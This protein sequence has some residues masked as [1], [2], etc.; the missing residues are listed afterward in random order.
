MRIKSITARNYK[1]HREVTVQLD[2]SCT[3]IGGPNECGK[4]TLAEAAHR[5][6]FLKAKIT[7][8]TQ[9]GMVPFNPGGQPEVE[10][11]FEAQGKDY[12]LFKRFSGQTGMVRLSE[13]GG[14]SWQDE[15]AEEQL[16]K[17]LAV[18]LAGG[19]RG[20]G[21]RAAQQWAH[22]WVWQGQAGHDPAKHANDHRDSLMSRLQAGGGAAVMQSDRDAQVARGF[23]ELCESI[24]NRNGSPKANSDLAKAVEKGKEAAAGEAEAQELYQRLQQAISDYEQARTAIETADTSLRLLT[25]Q[26][27]EVDQKLEQVGKL[28]QAE[29]LQVAEWEM[30]SKKHKDLSDADERIQNLRKDLKARREALQPKEAEANRLNVVAEE[31]KRAAKAALSNYETAAEAARMARLERDLAIAHELLFEKTE[32]HNQLAVKAEEVR[33]ERETRTRLE[34]ELAKLPSLDAAGLKKLR[35]LETE[36]SN[37]ESALKAMAA[38]IEV[39]NAEVP[40]NAGGTALATGAD[41]VVTEDTELTI[42]KAARLRIKPGGGTSLGQ[43]RQN[44]REANAKL[45]DSLDKLGLASLESASEALANRELTQASIRESEVRLSTLGADSVAEEV[46]AAQLAMTT[47]QGEVDRRKEQLEQFAAPEALAEAK[48]L[49]RRLGGALQEKESNERGLKAIRDEALGASET[50]D[51]Q[52]VNGRQALEK[53]NREIENLAIELGVLTRTH[54]EDDARSQELNRLFGEKTTADER[55][56]TTRSALNF[57]QPDLLNSDKTR[58]ER[59]ITKASQEKGDALT[60]QAVAR[61]RLSSDGTADPAASLATAEA[62]ARTA[63]E[64]L[65]NEQCRARAAQLIHNLFLEEQ[66]K[67]SEQITRPLVDKVSGYLQCLFGPG[68]QALVTLEENQFVGVR[69]AR[70]GR[71]ISACD[72]DQLSGGTREQVAA[73]FRLAMA[74]VLAE[75]YEGCLPVVFD[76]AFAYS[77]PE[78]VQTLQR[79]LD[80]AAKRGLQIIVLTCN[81]V[82]YAGLGAKQITLRTPTLITPPATEIDETLI[83]GSG[84]RGR[85]SPDVTETVPPSVSI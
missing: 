64:Q 9:K 24:F 4:S 12:R 78:R 2:P 16:A 50:A 68:A 42:G 56:A 47:A 3:V 7:G 49:A 25:P 59:A 81:P 31:K 70:P 1:T 80:L 11:C 21:E 55:L 83:S 58:L 15:A 10:V 27:G 74:E 75:S 46:S 77:D 40:V 19:G 57:L 33:K 23:A 51:E 30:A 66:R 84:R 20:A 14:T 17:M 48:D 41:H 53:E 5:A 35:K 61:D 67:L 65:A 36:R 52:A 76:D 37:A 13:V 73:A 63:R 26:K 39:I 44:L 34:G 8:E 18:E 85:A 79:M 69:I 28:Q 72:F 71:E 38:R 45:R 22:L 60:K 32:Q 29:K 54:G 62:K 6:F 43:A 82:D